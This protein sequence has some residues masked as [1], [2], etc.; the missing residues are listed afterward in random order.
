GAR[1]LVQA[2]RAVVD[3]GAHSP[4][5]PV[6]AS[7]AGGVG[8]LPRALAAAGRFTV[9]TSTTVR[10]I[11]R[12]TQG[13]ELICGPVPDPEL[14]SADAVIIA[15]PAAKAA[16]L[17]RDIAPAASNELRPITSASMAITTL[18][19]RDVVLPPG[20]GLLIG[21]TE[22]FTVKAVTISSQKWPLTV[23]P[24]LT[25]LRVSVGRAGEAH[26]LQREDSELIA[27]VRHDLRGLLGIEREPV[28]SLVTR[29]GGGLPQYAVGHVERVARVRAAV[30]QV[31]A[32]AVCGAAYDGVG[33]PACISSAQRA[34]DQVVAA[35]TARGQ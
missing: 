4:K 35:L 3:V 6:F 24:G 26:V 5:G 10:V 8:R 14:V 23:D 22:G 17:L 28:D 31:P 34:A 12:T 25:V 21:V 29:W 30:A 19:Y 13:F 9:R 27:I 16:L 7:L 11:T 15:A 2:A 18:A 20:S 1:S 33:I 32:L